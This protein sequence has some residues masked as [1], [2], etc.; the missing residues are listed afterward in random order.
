MKILKKGTFYIGSDRI[1]LTDQ[2]TEK[3]AK[4]Y[5]SK[6]PQM[7]K[8]IELDEDNKG[9]QAS[10]VKVQPKPKQGAGQRKRKSDSNKSK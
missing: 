4:G 2:T 9:K 10:N 3:E 8:Y 6:H 1:V 5:L 7:S